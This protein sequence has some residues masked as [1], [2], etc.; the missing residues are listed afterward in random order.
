[1]TPYEKLHQHFAR[2]NDLYHVGAV[3]Q[4]DEAAMMPAGGG[5]ARG[6]ALATLDGVTHQMLTDPRIGEWLAAADSA[7]LEP[8]QA[9]NLREMQRNYRDATCL[10]ESLVERRTLANS[11]CEQAWRVHRAENNWQAMAPL[12]EDVVALAREEAAAR[13]AV[14]GMSLYDSLL[15]SYEPGMTCAQLDPL[16]AELK[17]FLPGLLDATIE[18]Q[19]QQ[20]AQLPEGPFTIEEQRALGLAMMRT[21][22][23]DFEHGRLDVSHHPFCGGV[24]SDVRITTRYNTEGFTQALM[25]VIHETGHALYEQGLPAEWQSQPVGQALSTAGHESQSLLMEMQAC[26]S[27]EFLHYL[28]PHLQGSFAAAQPRAAAWQEDNL[29][30]LFTHVKRGYIRVDADEVSYPLHVILRYEIERQLIEGELEVAGIP[31]AWD[32]RMQSYLGLSTAGNYR[33]GCLQDVH[34]PAGLFGYFPTYTLGAMSAAQLFAA[35]RQA[36]PDMLAQLAEGNFCALLG[37]LREHVH[38]QGKF[39]DYNALMQRATGE[40]LQSSYFRAHLEARYLGKS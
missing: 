38:S 28:T 27:Q 30:R 19:Q 16:F 5:D 1:M 22:G 33:D 14:N 12:L 35:A 8:W 2:L 32:A 23:F 34:W 37:W 3:A 18:R 15:D 10:P 9:A 39:L 4:W 20:P 17:A 40:T 7:T 26:R 31:E 21:L 24:P 25:G 11:R 6:Q 36:L 29:Y 13:A